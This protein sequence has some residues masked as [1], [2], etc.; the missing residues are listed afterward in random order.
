MHSAI[1]NAVA[2]TEGAASML[3]FGSSGTSGNH[4]HYWRG[5]STIR[6]DGALSNSGF[7]T[8]AI[9]DIGPIVAS[10]SNRLYESVRPG[11]ADR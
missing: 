10:V 3:N 4:I 7:N 8:G 11:A 2:S 5:H 1:Q 9:F 6:G